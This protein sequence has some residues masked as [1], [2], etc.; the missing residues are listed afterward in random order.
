MRSPIVSAAFFFALGC[1]C[2]RHL[3]AQTTRAGEINHIEGTAFLDGKRLPTVPSP[4]QSVKNGSSLRTADGRVEVLLTPGTFLRLAPQSELQFDRLE[5]SEI[6]L[7]NG[8]ALLE[9]AEAR[10]NDASIGFRGMIVYGFEAGIYEADANAC[11]LAVFKGAAR[12]QVPGQGVMRLQAGQSTNCGRGGMLR[13]SHFDSNKVD[14]LYVWSAHAAEYEAAANYGVASVLKHNA[15]SNAWYWDSQLRCWA[16]IPSPP[17]IAEPF[18]WAFLAGPGQLANALVLN[19]PVFHYPAAVN[20]LNRPRVLS[21]QP[22]GGLVD[23]T[24]APRV[25][26]PDKTVPVDLGPGAPSILR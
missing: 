25:E 8:Q 1:T 14:A 20:A 15:R 22:N 10:D 13:T 7:V 23:L 6:R 24:H 16:F 18:G 3:C 11:R 12:I 9:V 19:G 2:G 4:F 17:T 21:L 26:R 5:Q